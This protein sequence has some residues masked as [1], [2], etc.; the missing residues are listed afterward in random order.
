MQLA[1]KISLLVQEFLKETPVFLVS[2]KI[3]QG[4]KK[5]LV[6]IDGDAGLAI[7]DCT[8]VSRFLSDHLEEEESLQDAYH[9]DVTSPGADEPLLIAR[10]YPK[11]V[12]RKFQVKTDDG[13]VIK[14][15]LK[16]FDGVSLVL[17]ELS[18][19]KEAIEHNIPM[20]DVKEARVMLEF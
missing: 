15:R 12:G 13:D 16:S 8:K 18:K 3:S 11:H 4:N 5:I 7:E 10:Q 19:K 9:L 1:A 14:G 17:E 6:I 20:L 2:V